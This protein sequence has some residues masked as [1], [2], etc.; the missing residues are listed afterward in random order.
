ME[1]SWNI[2][3]TFATIARQPRVRDKKVGSVYPVLPSETNT[4]FGGM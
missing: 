4:E 2:N 1:L 3:G